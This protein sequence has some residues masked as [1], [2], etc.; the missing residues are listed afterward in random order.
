VK[1]LPEEKWIPIEEFK[2][3]LEMFSKIKGTHWKLA[4][5][6]QVHYLTPKD[7]QILEEEISG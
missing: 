6:G 2:D 1:A 4:L 7:F 5:Q 3:K